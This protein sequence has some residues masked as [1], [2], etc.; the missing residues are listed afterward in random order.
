MVLTFGDSNYGKT[1]DNVLQMQDCMYYSS[2][3]M[4]LQKKKKKGNAEQK[5][6]QKSGTAPRKELEA[7]CVA[8]TIFAQ[9]SKLLKLRHVASCICGFET[10]WKAVTMQEH[11]SRRA[12]HNASLESF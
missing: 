2:M 5:P 7:R 8:W 4:I 3:L 10:N 11:V 1:S 9:P 6:L 12:I